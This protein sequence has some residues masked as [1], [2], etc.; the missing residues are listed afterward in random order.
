MS[1]SRW[2]RTIRPVSTLPKVTELRNLPPQ[3]YHHSTATFQS[4]AFQAPGDATRRPQE[5]PIAFYGLVLFVNTLCWQNMLPEF[6]GGTVAY[7]VGMVSFALFAW[8][9]LRE[10]SIVRP[11]WF[12]LLSALFYGW[13]GVTVF[14]SVAPD[15]SFRRL[16]TDGQL[17]LMTWMVFGLVRSFA[18]WLALLRSY[19][20][21][22]GVVVGA[23]L[24][25]WWFGDAARR[26][27]AAEMNPNEV[28][29]VA[30]L[31]IPIAWYLLLTAGRRQWIYGALG[32]A[33]TLSLLVAASRGGILAAAAGLPFVFF[34]GGR[35]YRFHRWVLF[36]FAAAVAVGVLVGNQT[37]GVAGRL[38]EIDEEIVSG[39][40]S[41]RGDIWAA[42]MQVFQE[43]LMGGIG[44]AGYRSATAESLGWKTRSGHSVFVAVLVEQ[45]IV[46]F[47]VLLILLVGLVFAVRPATPV[48]RWL[49]WTVIAVWCIAALYTDLQYYKTTWFLFT[50]VA[51]LRSV[52]S[53]VAIPGAR[54]GIEVMSSKAAP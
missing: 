48:E 5:N 51:L 41:G 32:M 54:N 21:G 22:A 12:I 42:G 20:F 13:G 7:L 9:V 33:A 25:S 15:A 2:W 39:H 35:K 6:G 30:A 43:N 49:A 16:L 38:G 17:W 19:F 23:V 47:V 53:T 26:Y 29:V 14:W 50:M 4:S 31:V 52:K 28:A 36:G 27:T 8:H 10:G 37:N 11:N 3:E 24:V 45:G 46:G 18:R 1:L 40:L 44:V 34:A